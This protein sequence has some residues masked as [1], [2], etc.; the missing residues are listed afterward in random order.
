MLWFRIIRP[1][2]LFASICPVLV[3]LMVVYQ[4]GYPI[5]FGVALTTL[6]CAM[7]LQI[8][9]NLI[10]DYYDFR[11]GTD[12]K[13]RVGFSRALAEGLVSDRQMLHACITTLTI[14]IAM[15]AYLV[16]AGGVMILLIG[17]LSILF[18]WLY[19][20][21]NHSLSYL[22][23]ADIFVF[24]FYGVIAGWGT[25]YLQMAASLGGSNW[26]WDIQSQMSLMTNEALFPL[27]KTLLLASSVNGL[28]SMCVLIIN[29]LRDLPTD[30][31]V[32][33]RTFPVRFGKRAGETGL[34]IIVLLMPVFAWLAFRLWIPMLIVIPALCLLAGVL[35]AEGKQYNFC[36]LGAGILNVIYTI[37]VGLM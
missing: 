35:R 29:N 36:L 16:W 11:R 22:G 26:L 6:L 12:Q 15:G 24:L 19:T 9:S 23:I 33:K 27:H 28:I 13:G 10:N 8:L 17:L 4:K 32:G 7:A 34:A 37:L 21:T 14:A 2:T 3:A 18:A 5:H 20:A 30:R 25:G 1:Q 31:E